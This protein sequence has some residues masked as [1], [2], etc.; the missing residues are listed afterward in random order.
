M[1]THLYVTLILFPLINQALVFKTTVDFIK[2]YSQDKL[3]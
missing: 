1:S 2:I 3:H